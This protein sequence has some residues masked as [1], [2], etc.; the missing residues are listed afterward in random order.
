MNTVPVSTLMQALVELLTEAYAGPPDPRRSWFIEN[1]PDSGV[2]GLLAQ[3]SAEQASSSVDGS[4]RPGSTIA[5][6]A[7]HLRWSLFNANAG[8]RGQ[9]FPHDW[10]ESWA[11]T[12][13]DA[14]Q[15][16]ELRRALRA[17]F[18]SLCAGF[19]QQPVLPDE[20]VVGVLALIPHAAFHLG[21]MRQML[22]RVLASQKTSLEKAPR[23]SSKQPQAA[24]AGDLPAGL[25]QPALRAL[26]GAGCQR[27]EQVA[28]LSETEVRRLHGVG[29][30]AL[31]KLRHAL[32][33]RG[34]SFA[35]E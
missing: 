29:P 2:L 12:R 20:Y 16:D 17:E 11:V 25:S 15:W 21:L 22:E 23:G 32:A 13:V 9:P 31:E 4:G 33:A 27:L 7:E 19:R 3:V 18:E 34:W 1:A 14:A 35:G 5:A 24:P 28:R 30:H 6:N 8:L 10:N 26:A